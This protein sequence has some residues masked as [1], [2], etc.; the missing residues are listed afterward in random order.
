MLNNRTIITIDNVTPYLIHHGFLDTESIVNNDFKILDASKKNRNLKIIRKH[1]VSYLLKQANIPSSHSKKTIQREASI[2]TLAQQNS[3]FK[4][5]AAI[6]PRIF[7]F[8]VQL[9]L[10][11][12]E[13]ITNGEPLNKYIYGTSRMEFPNFLAATLGDVIANYHRTFVNHIESFRFLP[14]AFHSSFYMFHPGPG[15]L[16]GLSSANLKLL[17]LIQKYSEFSNHF[18][19]L[20][21]NWRVQTLIHGDIRWD[22]ILLLFS[23]DHNE[24]VQIKL[25]DWEFADFGDP[26]W[27]IGCV[28]HDFV[29]FWLYSLRITGNESTE[30]LLTH[31]QLPLPHIQSAIRVFW[32]TYTKALGIDN[33]ESNEL[34]YRSTKYCALRLL[35]TVYESSY[36]ETELSNI[37]VY[38]VQLSTNILKDPDFAVTQL[39]GIPLRGYLSL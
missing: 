37:S 7:K 20:V 28:F 26:A 18:E 3:E 17:K 23:N 10:L 9:D 24:S 25:V 4:S 39:L 34:L 15:V 1:N 33:R 36:D 14:M 29:T 5:F 30:A 38:M 32:Y 27:D 6:V 19:S 13:L 16:A 21:N 2:Y 8:D 11:I 22:N 12:T 35:H 31:A